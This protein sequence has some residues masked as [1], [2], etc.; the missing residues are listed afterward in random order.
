MAL[1]RNP[2]D[3]DYAIRNIASGQR[4]WKSA[5]NRATDENTKDLLYG[6]LLISEGLKVALEIMPHRIER[7]HQ[8][9]DRVEKKLGSA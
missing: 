1:N 9:I 2:A 8:K 6:L 7:L 3:V 4:H 5:L